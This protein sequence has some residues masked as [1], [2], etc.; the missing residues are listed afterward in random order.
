MGIDMDVFTK[1]EMIDD[2]PQFAMLFEDESEYARKIAQHKIWLQSIRHERPAVS[3]PFKVGI[4]IR[5]FNQTKY[6]DYITYHKKQ[7]EDSTFKAWFD[8]SAQQLIYTAAELE[9]LGGSVAA[10]AASLEVNRNNIVALTA[11][12]G[13]QIVNGKILVD[14][15]GDPI[16]QSGKGLYSKIQQNSQAITLKVT[17]GDVSTQLAV[18]CGNVSITGGN[19][20]VCG[21]VTTSQLNSTNARIDNIL[22]GQTIVSTLNATNAYLGGSGGGTVKIYGQTVRIYNVTDTNGVTRYVFGYA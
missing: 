9:Q 5:Y 22:S 16:F 7:F 20:T 12:E 18:E 3:K 10:N 8:A 2:T 21:Y 14:A 15:N 1:L 19:L 6:Q 11:G 4:Y 17:K 13:V